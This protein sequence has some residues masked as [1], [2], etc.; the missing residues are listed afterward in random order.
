VADINGGAALPGGRGRTDF[1]GWLRPAG[2]AAEGSG[3]KGWEN[4]DR[5]GSV[6]AVLRHLAWF[7]GA[8]AETAHL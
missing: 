6:G 7:Y 8:R 5:Y 3:A 2:E 1:G 4:H